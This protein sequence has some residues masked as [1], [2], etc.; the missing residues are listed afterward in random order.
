MEAE[1]RQEAGGSAPRK[2]RDAGRATFLFLKLTEWVHLGFGHD[3]APRAKEL[4][5]KVKVFLKHQSILFE[6]KGGSRGKGECFKYLFRTFSFVHR[7]EALNLPPLHHPEASSYWE[8]IT[9][10]Y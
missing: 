3:H 6:G 10:S 4:L 8:P 2:A 1:E 7:V 9:V 5:C